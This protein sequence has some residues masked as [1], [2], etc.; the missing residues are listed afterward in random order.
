MSMEGDITLGHNI[1]EKIDQ[2][3]RDYL[4]RSP[5]TIE[6]PINEDPKSLMFS[7]VEAVM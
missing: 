7:I 2:E 3:A 4:I 6:K 1:L 5:L